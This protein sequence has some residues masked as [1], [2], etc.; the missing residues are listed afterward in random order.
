[1]NTVSRPRRQLSPQAGLEPGQGRNGP[2]SHP[3][4]RPGPAL[5]S[6]GRC[7]RSNPKGQIPPSPGERQVEPM[8]PDSS[9]PASA[10]GEPQGPRGSE[11]LGKG[12]SFPRQRPGARRRCLPQGRAFKLERG[13]RTPAGRRRKHPRGLPRR[14]DAARTRASSAGGRHP[15]PRAPGSACWKP[16]PFLGLY[17]SCPGGKR[18]GGGG[19]NGSRTRD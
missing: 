8:G 9:P 13:S 10:P 18:G 16:Q 1:M 3:H 2:T 14:R 5:A 6:R 7:G 19:A 12:H 11:P 4:P 15:G 17:F